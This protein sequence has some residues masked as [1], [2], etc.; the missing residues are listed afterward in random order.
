MT[1]IYEIIIFLLVLTAIISIHE[2]GH[3]LLAKK[4]HILVHEFSIGMGPHIIKKKKGDTYYALRVIPLGGYVSMS[5]ENG[6]FAYIKKGS[7][8]GINLNEI[9]L[10]KEITLDRTISN[11]SFTGEVLDFDLFGENLKPL[12]IEMKLEDG[13]IQRFQVE[14]TARYLY[15]YKK[16]IQITPHESSFASKTIWQRFLVLF[17]G[18]LM[19]FIMAFVIFFLIGIIQGKPLNDNKIAESFNSDLL[20]GDVILSIDGIET[21]DSKDIQNA[22][23]QIADEEVELKILRNNNEVTVSTY[24]TI[25][26]QNFGLASSKQDEHV[27]KVIIGGIG[28]KA[29]AAGLNLG[30]EIISINGILVHSWGDVLNIARNYND[31]SIKITARRDNEEFEV[32]FEVFSNSTIEAIGE[33]PVIVQLGFNTGYA[34]D[35]GYTFIYP[36]QA[37]GDSVTQ[38]ISTLGLL[39]N[40]RS[41]IGIGDLSGP[42]GIFSI[43]SSAS[44]SGLGIGFWSL[45]AFL[46][47]NIGLMNLLPIPALDGGRILFLGYEAITKKKVPAKVE[48]WVNNISFILLLALMLFVTSNDIIRLFK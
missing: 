12:F 33:R 48:M 43:V 29:K 1:L 3:F 41:G 22:L 45:V 35:L 4:A 8:I 39:F 5:G 15:N 6:D 10:V 18:P 28:Q 24:V 19:N 20:A 13:T 27:G 42:V 23:L 36:F 17:F 21:K 25:V 34:F 7:K 40:P 2:L 16:E 30:D 14:R 9:G 38:M 44:R 46:S 47:V 32:E 26:L 37:F 11:T 31:L